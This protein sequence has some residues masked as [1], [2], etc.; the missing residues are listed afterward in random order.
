MATY[1]D[2]QNW[3]KKEHGYTVKTCWI[4]HVKEQCGL[5][6]R[7]AGNRYSPDKRVH[8]CPEDKFESIRSAFEHFGMV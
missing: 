6:P 3:V 8:P 7:V 1:A 4:A 5:K 2:I